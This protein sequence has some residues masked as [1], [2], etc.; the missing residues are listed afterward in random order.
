[1]SMTRA[2]FSYWSALKGD[3]RRLLVEFW[4]GPQCTQEFTFGFDGKVQV[5]VEERGMKISFMDLVYRQCMNVHM[6]DVQ[7]LQRHGSS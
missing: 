2:A 5:N 1:M 3:C 6:L 7:E 4:L